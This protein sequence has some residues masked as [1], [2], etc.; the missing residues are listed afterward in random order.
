ML[1]L[2]FDYARLL[3]KGE[4]DTIMKF[5]YN[6]GGRSKY[7]KGHTGDCVIR[8]IAI[9]TGKDYKE[10]YDDIFKLS[11]D[12][13]RKGVE[14]KYCQKYL[15]DLGW[16]WVATMGIG[17]G[18]Q[19]HLNEDEIP[20]GTIIVRLSR[21]IA[22]VKDKVLQDIYDCSRGGKRCVYGYWREKE[23]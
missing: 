3:V 8:A 14:P 5:V 1:T 21:H 15:K 10:I 17:T 13:P 12:S 18:C 23:Q 6:D 16:E 2:F 7:F 9:A 20:D 4:S 19:I 11:G 22:C